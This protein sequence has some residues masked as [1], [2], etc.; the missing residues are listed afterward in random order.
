MFRFL[1]FCLAFALL[2]VQT[3]ARAESFTI[4]VAPH[5][6]ARVIVE[7]YQPLRLALERALGGS[8]EIITAP[9]FSEYARRALNQEYDL[10]I[11]TGHQ[12]RM[13][14]A[15]ANY[16][17]LL[18]YRADFKAI[19]V[20][21]ASSAARSARDLQ[22]GTVLGLSPTSLV[23]LWGLHWLK[24]AEVK[25]ATIRYVSAADS[26]AQ[27]VLAGEAAA[28]FISTA[29]FDK[30]APDVRAR[31]R[32]LEESEPMAGRVYLLN[33]RDA[34][35]QATVDRALW[36]FAESAEGKRY[37][38]ANKLDGYRKLRPRELE[39]MERYADEVRRAL[40]KPAP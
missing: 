16:Q 25:P 14:Q 31:L 24:D 19:A 35:R 32:V 8:V 12:A 9:D 30:L 7:Q 13:L 1:H 36:A 6:S 10:A 34:A 17:P 40:R 28:G 3:Q 5:T 21:A 2:A 29:N 38:A 22:G 20:V 18:T 26:V 15:D 27:L 4:G 33:Q 37:F 39:K 23:T 11:T